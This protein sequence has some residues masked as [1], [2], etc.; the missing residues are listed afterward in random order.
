MLSN[1]QKL[2]LLKI[3]L[4]FYPT[5]ESNLLELKRDFKEFE[6]KFEMIEKLHKKQ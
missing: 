4:K 2:D 6:W 5:P 1:R 3:D